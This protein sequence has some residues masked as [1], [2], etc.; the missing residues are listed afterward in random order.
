[1]SK[2]ILAAALVF[3]FTAPVV[4]QAS[5]GRVNPAYSE[6]AAQRQAAVGDDSTCKIGCWASRQDDTAA[7]FV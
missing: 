7:D 3:A 2:L 1:M 6:Q 4:A 5:A